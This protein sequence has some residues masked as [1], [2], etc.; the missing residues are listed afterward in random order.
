MT[1][2]VI[3]WRDQLAF[4]GAIGKNERPEVIGV[5]EAEVLVVGAG[6]AGLACA[7][8]LADAGVQTVVLDRA[9]GVGGRCATRRVDGRPVDHGLVFL[10]GSDPALLAAIEA[11]DSPRLDGWP[12]RVHG[13]GAPCQPAAFRAEEV[14]VAFE[15]GVSAFPKRLARGLDVRLGQDVHRLTADRGVVEVATRVGETCRSRTVVLALA[16]EQ[17]RPLL[18][19]L[20]AADDEVVGVQRLLATL[21][22]VPCLTLLAGFP[23]RVGEPPWDIAYPEDSVVFQLVCNDSAKRADPPLTTLVFQARPAWSRRHLD[24]APEAWSAEM[25]AEAGR[26]LGPWAATPTWTQAHR[27]LHA[28][29]EAGNELAAPVLLDLGGGARLGLAGELFA[30]GGGLQ[31]AFASGRRLAHRLIAKGEC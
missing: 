24:E 26:L 1:A 27:W 14:R 3:S 8:A 12:A 19:G 4:C 23:R 16:I 13:T 25:L 20:G 11:V 6:A 21:A 29:L 28:R 17:A 22:T 15:D 18:N 5:E 9:R 7:R 31:A 30:P 10:H 2:A